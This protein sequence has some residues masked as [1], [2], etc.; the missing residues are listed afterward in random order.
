MRDRM[1]AAS[2]RMRGSVKP[3]NCSV[4]HES[5]VMSPVVP[6]RRSI[7]L[8]GSAPPA[9]SVVRTNSRMAGV[10]VRASALMTLVD[11]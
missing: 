6:A 5:V 3:L 4:I 7:S 1:R 9:A 10:S 8:R 11:Q 2:N